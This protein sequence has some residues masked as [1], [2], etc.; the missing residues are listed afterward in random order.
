MRG[1]YYKNMSGKK[2]VLILQHIIDC[3]VLSPSDADEVLPI[4]SPDAA[5]TVA[6]T[7]VSS[8]SNNGTFP[9]I[10]S[11]FTIDWVMQVVAY[12]L[13]LPTLYNEALMGAMTI[14][15]HWLTTKD[16]FG[17]DE[18]RNKY[19][20]Q[21]FRYLSLIFE[22]RHDNTHPAARRELISTLM[23]DINNFQKSI[24]SEFDAETWEVLV[25]VLIGACDFLSRPDSIA[26]LSD[27]SKNDLLVQCFTLLFECLCNSKLTNLKIW[28][29]FFDFTKRWSRSDDFLNSWHRRVVLLWMSMINKLTSKK[30]CDKNE[31][32]LVGF[33]LQRFIECIDFDYIACN[34]DLVK[35]IAK[36]VKDLTEFCC[37]KTAESPALFQPLFPAELFF[38]LFGKWCFD[39]FKFDYSTGQATLLKS[40]MTIA[41]EWDLPLK[42]PW[43]KV[44]LSTVNGVIKKGHKQLL[45][46]ILN[47][48]HSMML[49][50]V[51][52]EIV[53]MFINAISTF[54]YSMTLWLSFWE[55]FGVLLLDICEANEVPMKVLNAFLDKN[56]VPWAEMNALS[57]LLRQAPIEFAGRINTI[58]MSGPKTSSS[59]RRSDELFTQIDVLVA[60]CYLISTA[61]AFIKFE[62]STV[63]RPILTTLLKFV[64]DNR[65]E[66]KLR[67]AFI[68]MVAQLTKWCDDV[69]TR[70]I[71][72][73][74]LD[75]LVSLSDDGL[76][77]TSEIATIARLICG[78][79]LNRSFQPEKAGNINEFC[80]NMKETE[81]DERLFMKP[82]VSFMSGQ[83]SLIT[84]VGDEKR[85]QSFV[86]H[87]R[88]SRGFFMW[89]ITDELAPNNWSIEDSPLQ[90]NPPKIVERKSVT[91]NYKSPFEETEAVIKQLQDKTCFD[92]DYDKPSSHNELSYIKVHKLQKIDNKSDDEV[93]YRLRHKAVDFLIQSGI[94]T[95][96]KKIEQDQNELIQRFDAIPSASIVTV[97]IFRATT[98]GFENQSDDL[99]ERLLS[100]LGAPHQFAGSQEPLPA[101]QLG[102][103]TVLYKRSD[104]SECDGFVSII[105]E[106]SPL[107]FNVKHSSIPK[108]ELLILI[109]AFD[110]KYYRLRAISKDASFWCSIISERIVAAERI[111]E[112]VSETIFAYT[113]SH[114][115]ELLFEMDK[116]RGDLL[117]SV[118]TSPVDVLD[119]AQEHTLECFSNVSVTSA[120]Q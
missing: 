81:K 40:I 103:L 61:P 74:M 72:V 64:S 21:I 92:E 7:I 90:L 93:P 62:S 52:K 66:D 120:S 24:G 119:I 112:V 25:R 100:L 20:R 37:A 43:T 46:S 115:R 59:M 29:V 102:L 36:A 13:S 58:C 82:L 87:V 15:R 48:G 3:G 28:S 95:N 12:C 69:F 84:L 5:S 41:G 67:N 11:Q 26:A 49:Q 42:S 23:N 80:L 89:E 53:E 47:N 68:V 101:V 113:A 39:S 98:N 106:E 57:I 19:A 6:V 1:C 118:K 70:P 109:K 22:Y 33:Q 60:I 104:I 55:S 116:Q 54:D 78:R 16:F 50:F 34:Q 99:L 97:P 65:R 88:D 76:I 77:E 18:N 73:D 63:I 108:C 30:E 14:F 38:G 17:S 85:G 45:V 86:F 107:Q 9:Q 111:S 4:F 35:N 10:E 117:R 91:S 94:F 56:T 44:V 8:F 31:L 51:S 32:T 96:I 79:S 2:S 27:S 75:F 114:R 105:F 83:S 71:S 110:S